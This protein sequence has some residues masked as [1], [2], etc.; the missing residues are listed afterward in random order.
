MPIT[1]EQLKSCVHAAG[2]PLDSRPKVIEIVEHGLKGYREYKTRS[3]YG[4][5]GT[6]IKKPTA[7]HHPPEGR[8]D[9]AGARTLLISALCRA[10]MEGFGRAPTLNNKKGSDSPF[11][12][13]A[14]R[15][16]AFEGIGKI[17]QHL[18]AYWAD[19]K[20]TWLENDST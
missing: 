4:P 8:H 12:E 10:W 14:M 2:F 13:F 7:A 17:H 20:K 16:M 1:P 11:F 3:Y 6:A 5:K 18:E 15:V 19:R 9:Q